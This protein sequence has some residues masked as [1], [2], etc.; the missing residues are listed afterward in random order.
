MLAYVLENIAPQAAAADKRMARL[1]GA[2]P[3][4]YQPHQTGTLATWRANGPVPRKTFADEAQWRKT[5]DGMLYMPP[6]TLPTPEMLL[7]PS[8]AER[9]DLTDVVVMPDTGLTLKILPALLTPRQI[10]DDNRLGDP[11]TEYGRVT[12]RLMDRIR[13]LGEKCLFSDV[14]DDMAD[15]CRLAIAFTY[16]MTR[17][18]LTDLGWLNEA[19]LEAIWEAAIKA[20]KA[21]PA[22]AGAS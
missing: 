1:A 7:R 3:W 4:Q 9:I 18:L 10:M 20:P 12:R 5:S 17:E 2:G 21:K 19:S 8:M 6:R 15:V 13:D 14:A 16:R 11:C 22:A